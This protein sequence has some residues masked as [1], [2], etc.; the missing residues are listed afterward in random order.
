MELYV[1]EED[2]AESAPPFSFFIAKERKARYRSMETMIRAARWSINLF[3]FENVR[4]FLALHAG[5]VATPEG[6][7]LLP[8]PPD[9]GKTTMVA[10][11]L[12]RGF[13]YLS[14]E[15]GAI[16]P[17]TTKVY[18]FQRRLGLNPDQLELFP[19]VAERVRQSRGAPSHRV[20]GTITHEDLGAKVSDPVPPRYLV[21]MTPNRDGP[22]RLSPI[23]AAE[24]VE[25]MAANCFNLY[26]YGDRGVVLLTRLAR[27]AQ[28]LRLEGGTARERTELLVER[29][30]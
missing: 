11:L 22:P 9:T 27:D 16:D 18:P 3:A 26:R 4:A 24:A 29:F 15:V 23:P 25:Q 19:E 10:A 21:F 2:Q 17:V 7:L 30:G 14:D 1:A 12:H 5:S 20:G 6:A 13:G 8:A 28:A